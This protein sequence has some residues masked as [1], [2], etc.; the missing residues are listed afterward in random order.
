MRYKEKQLH[1]YIAIN[2][3]VLQSNFNTETEI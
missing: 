3:I 2:L 1:L